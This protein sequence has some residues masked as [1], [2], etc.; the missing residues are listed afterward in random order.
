M[1]RIEVRALVT[2]EQ[3]DLYR[4]DT[5]SV[6]KS[7]MVMKMADCLEDVL[8]KETS[9][10]DRHMTEYA[11]NALL[12]QELEVGALLDFLK[13]MDLEPPKN[14]AVAYSSSPAHRLYNSLGGQRWRQR[15]A[16]AEDA[17]C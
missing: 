8:I 17:A 3:F 1:I 5:E 16:Q 11:C 7:R 6:V 13:E 4:K 14:V 15:M 9:L 12:L 2:D 10:P